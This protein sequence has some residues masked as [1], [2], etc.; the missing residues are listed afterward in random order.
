MLP[1]VDTQ[2]PTLGYLGYGLLFL[3]FCPSLHAL[4]LWNDPNFQVGINTE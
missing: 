1:K 4:S 3:C 2:I